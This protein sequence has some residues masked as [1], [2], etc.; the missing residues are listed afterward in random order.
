M[1]VLPLSTL[2]MAMAARMSGPLLLVW[3]LLPLLL[4][5]TL[6]VVTQLFDHY[7]AL[8]DR[9]LTTVAQTLRGTLRAADLPGRLGGEEFAVALPQTNLA[10][11][12]QTAE[13]LRVAIEGCVVEADA[14]TTAAPSD[15]LI[16]F[17]IS[18]GVAESA[19]GA[20]LA[21]DA[22]LAV[23]DRRLYDAK[24]HGRNRVVSDDRL[25][26]SEAVPAS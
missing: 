24:Q 22:L 21:L 6:R 4:W 20:P 1:D 12:A 7:L 11:A 10:E 25:H 17:R 5:V 23:A 26:A 8:G 16:R 15:R 13:R 3:L 14:D 19:A 18:V 2:A 9:V